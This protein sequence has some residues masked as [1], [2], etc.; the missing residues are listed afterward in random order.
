MQN[1]F[2]ARL[3]KKKKGGKLL[4]SSKLGHAFGMRGQ[5]GGE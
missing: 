5:T 4:S 3:K 1:L 2:Y